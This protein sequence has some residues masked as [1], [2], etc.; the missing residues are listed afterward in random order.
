MTPVGPRSYKVELE[1]G[2]VLRRNRRH[3]R[4][5]SDTEPTHN[6]HGATEHTHQ[7]VAVDHSSVPQGAVIRSG[8][9]IHRPKYLNDYICHSENYAK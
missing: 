9:L 6:G 5:S 4:M 2:S 7:Q 3:L 8:R 1:N